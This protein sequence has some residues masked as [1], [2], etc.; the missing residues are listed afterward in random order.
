MN[1]LSNIDL[2]F[3]LSSSHCPNMHYQQNDLGVVCLHDSR[4]GWSWLQGLKEGLDES[5][6]CWWNK[7]SKTLFKNLY[8]SGWNTVQVF[9]QCVWVPAFINMALSIGYLE[10]V[11]WDK[12]DWIVPWLNFLF[13]TCLNRRK[14][15]LCE[16]RGCKWKH[17]L[18]KCMLDSWWVLHITVYNIYAFTSSYKAMYPVV[19]H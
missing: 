16:L 5:L 19:H 9:G 11:I 4:F 8:H 1:V 6:L 17:L 18:N 14:C 13:E 15:L 12:P 10:H 2:I 3:S 7:S